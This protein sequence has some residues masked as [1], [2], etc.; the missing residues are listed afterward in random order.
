M[1]MI[2]KNYPDDWALIA[3]AIKECNHWICQCCGK[4]CRRPGEKFDSHRRTLT[5]AHLPHHYQAKEAF[6]ACLCAAC[7]LQI[8]AAYHASRRRTRRQQRQKK[9]GQLAL[10]SKRK[11]SR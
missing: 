5:I 7:H 10:L 3:H 4:Q 1:P 11:L 8:D 2:K 6:L 9:A